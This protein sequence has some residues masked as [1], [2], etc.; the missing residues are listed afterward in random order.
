M[1]LSK[2]GTSSL[3]FL[4]DSYHKIPDN[5]TMKTN[6]PDEHNQPDPPKPDPSTLH[7]EPAIPIPK[8]AE[9][10]LDAIPLPHSPR[11]WS[12][13]PESRRNPNHPEHAKHMAKLAKQRAKRAAERAKEKNNNP[14]KKTLDNN[15]TTPAIM[16]EP[17]ESGIYKGNSISNKNKSNP[18]H[19]PSSDLIPTDFNNQPTHDAH[20]QR[21]DRP[22]PCDTDNNTGS[23]DQSL[24]HL[25]TSDPDDDKPTKHVAPLADHKPKNGG[26]RMTLANPDDLGTD[27]IPQLKPDGTLDPDRVRVVRKA[28]A[29]TR[30]RARVVLQDL[31]IHANYTHAAAAAGTSPSMITRLMDRDPTFKTLCERAIEQ[32]VDRMEASIDRR[33]FIGVPRE[34]FNGKGELVVREMVYSDKLAELRVRALRPEV[35]REKRD[36]VNVN[37]AIGFQVNLAPGQTRPKSDVRDISADI[38]TA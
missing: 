19:T 32:A 25:P 2:N 11:P 20:Q 7:T 1:S 35:Y 34:R 3:S 27:I 13:H 14:P 24:D 33:A 4:I 16:D 22:H 21:E 37:V 38:K 28:V 26:R 9:E 23:L 8:S 18:T 30:A 36:D 29:I 12:E 17:T 31:A 10:M 15:T 5:I 6:K